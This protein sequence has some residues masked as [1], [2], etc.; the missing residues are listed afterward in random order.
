M[1]YLVSMLF[2]LFVLSACSSSSSSGITADCEDPQIKGNLTTYN[3]EK[4]YHVP[5]GQY[6]DI[7]DAEEYFCTEEEAEEAGFRKSLR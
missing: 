1:R 2:L 3:G 4:I 6:Y 7:T 5:G